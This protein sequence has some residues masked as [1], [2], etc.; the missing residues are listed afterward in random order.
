[1]LLDTDMCICLVSTRHPDYPLILLS[2]RDEFLDR[3]TAQADWWEQPDGHVL[4][5]RDL[6][7]EEKGTWLGI[8]KDGRL[9]AL[10]NFRDDGQEV[11]RDKSRGL[12]PKA[13]LTTPLGQHETDE[14]FA[15]RLINEVGIHD[16]G[17]FT[18]LFGRIRPLAAGK[19]SGFSIISNR[20]S[21]AAG[22]VKIAG[23]EGETHGLS[24]SH[25]GDLTWPKV[26]HGEHL[27]S[28]TITA[29][30]F[31]KDSQERFIEGLFDVLGVNTMR[32]RQP[33]EDWATYTRQLRN[34][35]FI[36]PVGGQ[37]I[38]SKPVDEITVGKG[39]KTP[40]HAE[41]NIGEPVYGTQKQTV[42]LVHRDGTVVFTERTLFDGSGRPLVGDQR[43]RQYRF[44]IDGWGT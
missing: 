2:N 13:Y 31:R 28:Q 21:S 7:R 20:T 30:I 9:A 19:N 23:K 37:S 35:V 6:Q 24:N 25:F 4:G 11:A 29:S 16:V 10:T 39:G 44:R 1:M 27:M 15:Q 41:V 18:L 17:G 33:S 34:S 32:K 14:D 8:T 43:Q 38:A 42:I 40:D 22:L 36:P 5:G 26:V 3:P 12:I